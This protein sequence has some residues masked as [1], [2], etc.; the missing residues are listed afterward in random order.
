MWFQLSTHKITLS[1]MI[2]V[3][4]IV[5]FQLAQLWLNFSQ[6]N[7]FKLHLTLEPR[8]YLIKIYTLLNFSYWWSLFC[9]N[10]SISRVYSPWFLV[11]NINILVVRLWS[12]QLIVNR[13]VRLIINRRVRLAFFNFLLILSFPLRF[14]KLFLF[15]SKLLGFWFGSWCFFD[16]LLLLLFDSFTLLACQVFEFNLSLCEQKI[17][18]EYKT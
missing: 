7:I 2:S 16:A 10:R 9:L 15:A 11:L 8:L 6:T 14:L 3:L 18:H 12:G 17:L 1:I 5:W 13:W 4:I